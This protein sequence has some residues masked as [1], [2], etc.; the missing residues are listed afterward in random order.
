MGASLYMV[1]SAAG[2]PVSRIA[3]FC[4]AVDADMVVLAGSRRTPIRRAWA[5][6]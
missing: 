5:A 2:S 1:R 3:D 6:A 4:R